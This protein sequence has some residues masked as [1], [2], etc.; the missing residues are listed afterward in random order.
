MRCP[1]CGEKTFPGDDLCEACG[2]DLPGAPLESGQDALIRRL[3]EEPLSTLPDPAVATVGPDEPVRAAVEAMRSRKAGCVAVLEGD[4]VVGI[5][6][7]R[8]LL[9]K[10]PGK[11]PEIDRTRVRDV[12]TRDPVVLQ[13]DDSLAMAL[14]KMSVGGYRHIPV[15]HEGRLLGIASVRD[16]FD[17]LAALAER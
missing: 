14:H 1:A 10:F 3:H 16:L 12:M 7:E 6:T 11:A 2:F 4:Q 17:R 9:L 13:A 5:L 15:M 8:D